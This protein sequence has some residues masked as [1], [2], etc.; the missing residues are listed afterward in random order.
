MAQTGF[1]E[2]KQTR[3]NDQWTPIRLT[4]NLRKIYLFDC[5]IFTWSS[6][7]QIRRIRIFIPTHWK[8]H[9]WRRR[10]LRR[11]WWRSE[12]Q[13]L[14]EENNRSANMKNLWILIRKWD[15][16][17]FFA[18]GGLAQRRWCRWYNWAQY[19]TYRCKHEKGPTESRVSISLGQSS[20]IGLESRVGLV[21]GWIWVSRCSHVP[22]F[23]LGYS[24]GER[25]LLPSYSPN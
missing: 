10:H 4:C 3:G 24:Y 9:W 1:P 25:R 12:N 8:M 18:A 21:G 17:I 20:R 6:R 19:I 23:L 22:N 7:F 15:M 5:Y 14:W 2:F 16:P 13:Q 11:K